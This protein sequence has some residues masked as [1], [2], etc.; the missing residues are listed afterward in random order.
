MAI[1]DGVSLGTA[2]GAIVIS[3]ESVTAAQAKVKAASI[4]MERDFL[5]L[6]KGVG[7]L[8]DAFGKLDRFLGGSLFAGVAL[9]AGKAAFEMGKASAQ[10]DLTRQSFDRLAA[11]VG[12]SSD[13]LL[14]SM[15]TA[16]RG[17]ISDSALILGANRAIAG[18]VADNAQELTQ[19][20]DIARATGQAFGYT[21]AEAFERII[22]ATS[23]L[24]TESLDELG[25]SIRLEQ[26]FRTYATT[27]G[28]T[29]DELTDTQRKQA[30]LNE[31]IRQTQ[32][33]VDA[34]AG[35]AGTAA[36][37]YNKLGVS[38]DSLT[39]TVG[40]F[41]NAFGGPNI[42]DGI[43]GS[44]DQ[45]TSKLQAYID[46]LMQIRE[47][48]EGLAGR[49]GF[50]APGGVGGVPAW[51]TG[52]SPA[53]SGPLGAA[54]DIKGRDQSKMKWAEGVEEINERTHAAII[55]LE[56]DFG[57]QRA[58]TVANYQK[59]MAREAADFARQR[60]NAER[61]LAMSILDI[62]QDSA[63]QRVKW[64]A[65]LARMIV[66]ARADSAE[67]VADWEEDHAERIAE[68]R[69]AATERLTELEE[70]YQRN[71]ER[72][73]EDHSDK[74]MDA[75]GRLDAKAV[76]EQQRNFARQEKDAKEAHDEQRAEL[77]EQ[78]Q[79]RI[80]QENESYA[81]R[82]QDEAKALDKSIRQQQEAHSRQLA[83]QA[84]NDRL[85]IEDM[86]QAFADQ[87]AQE[88][89][90]R[91]IRL[92]RQAEDHND[93]L[94]EMDRTHGERVAQIIRHAQEERTELDTEHKKEMI[95][96]K[97]RNDAWLEE[98]KRV[99]EERRKVYDQVWGRATSMRLPTGASMGE[100][101][102]P[103]GIDASSLFT[104]S[105][106]YIMPA[107]SSVTNSSSSRSVNVASVN[108]YA[109]SNQSPQD[110][111]SAVRAELVNIIESLV[112]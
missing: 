10:A 4:T 87:K 27:L 76:Y 64:E 109:A 38:W 46:L 51:M 107:P 84:D 52:V 1:G 34:A 49:L 110:I 25:I 71:R 108:V 94:I 67:R 112:D 2:R 9:G 81:E 79:E 59:S 23:R 6:N 39:K 29:S 68:V 20:L 75:A 36:D 82:L 100:N 3:T 69:E 106:S 98:L 83:E 60:A 102:L 105:S 104:P 13:A 73:A 86:K 90:E 47:L 35:S 74:L 61:E 50:E 97:V 99:E 78:L 111:A 58:S 53:A 77:Q 30:V 56:S 62:H 92:Q 66:S 31:V 57:R 28:V 11:G 95:A 63:R 24:E 43:A 5:R 80:D 42:V 19:I 65:D 45:T 101:A 48:A 14:E 12:Q 96:L 41:M 7:G 85:R 32:P 91:G 22:S 103:P 21:T 33:V 17:V 8:Q 16:S 70:D 72:A 55:Q 54:P 15:R 37:R 89:I 26:A 88:D 40:D 18:S 44:I 93:Q